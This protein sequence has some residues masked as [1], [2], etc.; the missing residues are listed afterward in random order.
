MYSTYYE[1][2]ISLGT[3]VW[4]V[5]T[6]DHNVLPTTHMFIHT[7]NETYLVLTPSHRVLPVHHTLAGTHFPSVWVGGWVGN[8]MQKWPHRF[9]FILLNFS[10]VLECVLLFVETV[11]EV[12][13]VT[14]PV[15]TMLCRCSQIDDE[16]AEESAEFRWQCC[17]SVWSICWIVR[18]W[19]ES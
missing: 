2:L 19:A 12:A 18:H 1:L 5:L 4:H 3:E 9:I 14:G 16:P 7:W 17:S 11:T 13:Y 10:N 8:I 15:C 6:R